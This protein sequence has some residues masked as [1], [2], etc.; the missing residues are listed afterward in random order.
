[1]SLDVPTLYLV[2]TLVAAML[3]TL[4]LFFWRQEKIAALGW[5]GT[6]YIVGAASIGIWTLAAPMLSRPILLMINGIGFAACG[7][8]WNAARVFHGRKPG[9]VGLLAG[10]VLWIVAALTIDGSAAFLRTVIGATIVAAYAALTASELWSERRR[11]MHSRWPAILVPMLHGVVLMLPVVLGGLLYPQ[12]DNNPNNIWVVVFAIELVFYSIGTVFVILMMVNDRQ[13]QVHKT[14]ASL[15]PLTGLLNRRGFTEATTR[16]INRETEAGRPVTVMIFDIDHFKSINDRFGHA[17]GDEVLKVFAAVVT[18]NLRITDLIGRIGG[19]EFA[20]MLPCAL[21]ES[22]VAAERVRESFRSSGIEINNV[23]VETTVSIG[24]SGGLLD[25]ELDVL[26]ASADAA[27]YRAKRS[28]RNRIETIGEKSPSLDGSLM[29]TLS[30]RIPVAV[31]SRT[32]AIPQIG[33]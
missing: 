20:A 16:M 8:M 26:L 14:A 31:T 10:A 1:M 27:L 23:A 30:S 3:G 17:T 22:L 4:L 7:M 21:E 2:A 6:A 29:P 13:V 18:A 15:D 9:W 11:S 32:S 12:D 33:R 5:W 24:I 25:A 28:G 19:E